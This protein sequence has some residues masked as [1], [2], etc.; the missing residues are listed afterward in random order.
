MQGLSHM[1]TLRL[2]QDGR[3]HVHHTEIHSKSPLEIMPQNFPEAVQQHCLVSQNT[4]CSTF[5]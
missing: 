4:G 2:G 5:A 1:I 3:Q